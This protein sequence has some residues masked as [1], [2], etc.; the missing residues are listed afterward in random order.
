MYDDV[1]IHLTR[2]L[3]TKYQTKPVKYN[4]ILLDTTCF[5]L[6]GGVLEY[7]LHD[8]IVANGTDRKPVKT[9]DIVGRSCYADRILPEVKVPN[10][11]V[12]DLIAFLDTGAYQEV[13]SANFNGLPKPATILVTGNK[14]EIIKRADTME[15]V[16]R[17]DV[18]P[19]RLKKCQGKQDSRFFHRAI[20]RSGIQS[21]GQDR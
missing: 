1:G 19:E 4:W 8:F 10:V 2:V 21:K 11:Q 7:N 15:D 17:R 13:S 18:V 9:A 5:F 12:G 3:K 16:F 20:I 6:A 14:A